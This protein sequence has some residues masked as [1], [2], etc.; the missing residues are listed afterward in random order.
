MKVKLA[1][2]LISTTSWRCKVEWK[3]MYCSTYI[4]NLRTRWKWLVSFMTL[5]LYPWGKR[6][7]SPMERRLR[8]PQSWSGCS[9]EGKN[10]FPDP[11]SPVVQPTAKTLYWLSYLIFLYLFKIYI[12]ILPSMLMPC[13]WSFTVKFDNKNF[14]CSHLFHSCYMTHPSSLVSLP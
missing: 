2:C 6:P 9:G 1:L 11:A 4:L 13:K 7:W 10:P 12:I 8:G 5:S 14:A 3:Y